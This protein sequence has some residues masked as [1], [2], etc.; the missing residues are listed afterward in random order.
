[1]SLPIKD[2]L[3][4]L[5]EEGNK[6]QKWGYFDDAL[7]IFQGLHERSPE[8]RYILVQYGQC[9][10]EAGQYSRLASLAR[11]RQELLS[12]K[13]GLEINWSLLLLSADVDI[14]EENLTLPKVSVEVRDLLK[15][16]WPHLNSTEV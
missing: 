1:M 4:D 11:S 14:Q 5:L 6:L 12:S 10:V 3:E 15:R 9:L 13:D 2:D 16:S 7:R 8:D